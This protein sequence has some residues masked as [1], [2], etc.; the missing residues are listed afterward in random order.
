M[1]TGSFE[2]RAATF[3][4]RLRAPCS[5]RLDAGRCLA[6][7]KLSRHEGA[8]AVELLTAALDD[9]SPLVQVAAAE[10]L[11]RI[12][13]PR[14]VP[15]LIKNFEG[16]TYAGTRGDG[17]PEH[18]AAIIE[19]AAIAL[20]RIGGEEVM[21][22]LLPAARGD[23]GCARM[24]ATGAA[25]GFSD[26]P[27]AGPALFD[28]LKSPGPCPVWGVAAESL[29]RLGETESVGLMR[30]ALEATR[31]TTSVSLVRAIGH[32]GG[33]RAIEA[34]WHVAE[35]P[36]EYVVHRYHPPDL[37]QWSLVLRAVATT[38]LVRL[39]EIGREHLAHQLEKGDAHD[40]L[41]AS[42]ALLETGSSKAWRKVEAVSMGSDTDALIV[43]V[44]G[45]RTL[46][47][48][49]AHRILGALSRRRDITTLITTKAKSLLSRLRDEHL[50]AV[51]RGDITKAHSLWWPGRLNR[52][53]ER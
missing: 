4:E 46:P 2:M 20:C 5:K 52:R 42:V 17:G 8:A 39:G 31:D 1:A 38:S 45:L 35:K 32:L 10:G 12:R 19:A 44:E 33:K 22:L 36:Q 7:Q 40:S 14:A 18:L 51:Q 53:S 26:D 9:G 28:L 48:T 11:G 13:D 29:A 41:V 16:G 24:M 6:V 27:R 21:A 15:A 25:L 50:D 3:T 34:L 37:G 30:V 49:K 47:W 23:G 43:V